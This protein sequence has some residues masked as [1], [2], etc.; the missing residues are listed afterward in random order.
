MYYRYFN[1]TTL[2]VY[3]LNANHFDTIADGLAYLF[4]EGYA[5]EG[6]QVEPVGLVELPA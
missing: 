2:E 1:R 6:D 3:D 5:S 4:N